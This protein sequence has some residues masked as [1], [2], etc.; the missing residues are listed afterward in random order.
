MSASRRSSSRARRAGLSSSSIVRMSSTTTVCPESILSGTRVALFLPTRASADGTPSAPHGAHVDD[1]AVVL[2]SLRSGDGGDEPQH[3]SR[4]L[5]RKF[6]DLAERVDVPLGEDEQVRLG[7]RLNV[8]DRYETVGGVNMVA[9]RHELAEEAV[10]LRQ[11]PAPPRP[12]RQPPRPPRARRSARRRATACSR[13]RS[14]APGGRRARHLCFPPGSTSERDTL[15]P[16]LRG[17]ARCGPLDV[18]RDGIVARGPRSRP[19]R[20]REDMHLGDADCLHGGHR[21]RERALVLGREADDHVGREVEVLERLDAGAVLPD[22]VT[23]PHRAQ[24]LVVAR[25]Q[26]H[27]KMPRDDGRLAHRSDQVGGDVIDLDR[28]EPQALE[29]VDRPRCPDQPWSV[30]PAARSRKQPRLTP[31]STTSW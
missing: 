21:I 28:R 27:V 8:A 19:R 5:V 31:V 29:A 23:A 15:R 9:V 6:V 1:H 26:R 24:H 20:V 7:G 30:M 16:T 18:A 14:Q 3:P 11:R 17:A 12:R 25:L 13:P 10:R 2:E 4:F 22:C